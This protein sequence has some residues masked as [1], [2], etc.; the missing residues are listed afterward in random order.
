MC[1][2]KW[3]EIQTLEIIIRNRKKP[4]YPSLLRHIRLVDEIQRNKVFIVKSFSTNHSASYNG[5]G[6]YRVE[7]VALSLPHILYTRICSLS[8]THCCIFLNGLPLFSE[9]GKDVYNTGSGRT[10]NILLNNRAV[11]ERRP[12]SLGKKS[13][14]SL[15]ISLHCH[16]RVL[17]TKPDQ[18]SPNTW[19]AFWQIRR[20]CTNIDL[21]TNI[22]TWLPQDKF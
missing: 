4:T 13:L 21:Y 9:S 7:G 1:I 15:F 11:T 18:Q 10:D 22:L 17:H 6:G 20:I 12:F 2:H 8:Q 19:S 14:L 16:K 5:Y 3:R